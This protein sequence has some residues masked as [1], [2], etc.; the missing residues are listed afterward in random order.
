MMAAIITGDISPASDSAHQVQ[1]FRRGRFRGA[2][3]CVAA[4]LG[5]E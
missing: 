4:P 5:G 1:H 2:Q 3:S